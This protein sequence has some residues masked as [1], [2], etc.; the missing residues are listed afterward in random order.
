MYVTWSECLYVIGCYL[1]VT[2]A[3]HSIPLAYGSGGVD[4]Q[5][6][7]VMWCSRGACCLSLTHRLVL[8]FCSR[9]LIISCMLHILVLWSLT[10]KGPHAG[11]SFRTFFMSIIMGAL[12]VPDCQTS[13]DVVYHTKLEVTVCQLQS[14]SNCLSVQLCRPYFTDF[15]SSISVVVIYFKILTL[16]LNIDGL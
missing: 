12:F 14:V 11:N 13:M 10:K 9:D 2:I 1:Q 3:T 5:V 15:F 4:L 7:M 8:T 16:S 6:T